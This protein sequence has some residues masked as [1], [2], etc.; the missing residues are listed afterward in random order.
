MAITANHRSTILITLG[1]TL[2]GFCKAIQAEDLLRT[3]FLAATGTLVSFILTLVLKR[4]FKKW[5]R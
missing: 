3:S 2:T 1:G 4:L 5:M